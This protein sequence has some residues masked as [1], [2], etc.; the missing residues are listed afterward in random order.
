MES[1]EVFNPEQSLIQTDLA[2]TRFNYIDLE[3]DVEDASIT[4]V[5]LDMISVYCNVLENYPEL[6]LQIHDLVS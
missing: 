1:G 2:L 3:N 6:L 5:F 4:K